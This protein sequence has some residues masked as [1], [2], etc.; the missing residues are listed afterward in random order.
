M[1]ELFCL[2]N[3]GGLDKNRVNNISVTKK[4]FALN[5]KFKAHFNRFL[6]NFLPNSSLIFMR[7][8][9]LSDFSLIKFSNGFELK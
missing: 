9:Y 7:T 1:R 2:A 5:F 6:N 4:E 3:I 8:L